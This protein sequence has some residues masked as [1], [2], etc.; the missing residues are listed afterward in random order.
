MKKPTPAKAKRS[1]GKPPVTAPARPKESISSLRERLVDEQIKADR[2]ETA[3]QIEKAKNRRLE[4]TIE[5]LQQA[6]VTERDRYMD[7]ADIPF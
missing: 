5:A 3:L 7:L 2:Y 4:I 6:M 1:S